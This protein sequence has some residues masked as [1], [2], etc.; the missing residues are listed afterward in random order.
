MVDGVRSIF[1][2]VDG[3]INE[4]HKPRALYSIEVFNKKYVCIYY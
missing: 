2:H 4:I 3:S 1:L